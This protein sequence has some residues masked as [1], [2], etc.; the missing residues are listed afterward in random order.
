MQFCH[1]KITDKQN[2]DVLSMIE[3][4]HFAFLL[5]LS[6]ISHP[7]LIFS[8]LSIVMAVSGCEHSK[9]IE[10]TTLVLVEYSIFVWYK[11]H[12]YVRLNVIDY[13]C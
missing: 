4:I 10:V 6:C 7:M 3:V 12:C 11:A 13:K 1:K 2:M 8:F 5:L 9:Y